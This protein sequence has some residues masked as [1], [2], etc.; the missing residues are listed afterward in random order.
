MAEYGARVA[1]LGFPGRADSPPGFNPLDAAWLYGKQLTILG[2]GYTPRLECARAAL[3]F[4]L[5][6]NLEFILQSMAS[7][8]IDLQPLLT[9]HL[10]AQRMVEAYELASQH[11]K[12]LIAAVF[13]WSGS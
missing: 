8:A 1:V 6:R 13:D 4:N 9:H 11:D 5:R 2:A 3:R 12:S 7:G 10:P